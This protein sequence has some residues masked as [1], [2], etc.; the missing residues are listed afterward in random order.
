LLIICSI[1]SAIPLP[2]KKQTLKNAQNALKPSVGEKIKARITGK[3]KPEDKQVAA[4]DKKS[5]AVRDED[6]K[7][8][9]G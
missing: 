4:I 7:S 1:V 3:P 5:L 9:H 2:A 6:K 8:L